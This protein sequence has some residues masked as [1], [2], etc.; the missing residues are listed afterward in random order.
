MPQ[1]Y[2]KRRQ[3]RPN[4]S[5]IFAD[6]PTP[7][8]GHPETNPW[9]L[10]DETVR[11]EDP[12]ST[13][14]LE[15]DLQ[16][17]SIHGERELSLISASATPS[18]IPSPVRRLR[19]KALQD[20]DGNVRRSPR[21]KKK[22]EDDDSSTSPT[23]KAFER[24]ERRDAGPQARTPSREATDSS[25]PSSVQVSEV[26][27]PT[28]P[29]D[30]ALSHSLLLPSCPSILPADVQLHVAPLLN[31]TSTTPTS[32]S[33]WASQLTTHFAITKIAEASYGEVYRL[34]LQ[35]P[36]PDF[37]TAHESVLKLIAL[38]PPTPQLD[39]LT[40][41]Q[42]E[43]VAA[44]SSPEAVASEVR[45]LKHMSPTPGFAQFR[46]L[47][48]ISGAMPAP[49]VIAWRSY[50]KNVKKSEFPDP[51][52]KQ[53]YA[54]DQ[55]W[56]VVE[57]QDAGDDLEDKSVPSIFVVWDIFWAVA[58]ALAKGEV[59]S[60]FEHRDLHTGNVCVRWPD[61]FHKGTLQAGWRDKKLGLTGVDVTLIDYTLSRAQV[62]SDGAQDDLAYLDLEK[63][64]D[65]FEGDGDKDYQYDIYRYMRSAVLYGDA[66]ADI[67]PPSLSTVPRSR[68]G[69]QKDPWRAHN[70]VTN[71]IWLHF[72]LYKLTE[73][74]EEWP[75]S[76]PAKKRKAMPKEEYTAALDLEGKV[77]ELWAL[78]DLEAMKERWVDEGV[79]S[80]AG[81]VGWAVEE[82]WLG[83]DD[84]LG[85]GGNEEEVGEFAQT[86]EGLEQ[87]M[88]RLDIGKGSDGACHEA[89]KARRGRPRKAR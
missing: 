75:S 11:V 24:T 68:R 7:E 37:N 47:R 80:A 1:V 29:L 34:S 2:G 27:T 73:Q 64:L 60:G 15:T 77:H 6:T 83:A 53:A 32:F 4:F 74:L 22:Y 50:D 55:L 46:D 57:M 52:R 67:E 66:V 14:A 88:A 62:S 38:K 21:I 26:L 87:E 86:E 48:I 9:P 3:N 28:L 76:L 20:S 39:K 13:C 17:L 16:N 40:C 45:L 36:H 8:K 85:C 70:P 44:M 30:E 59:A 33:N 42:R 58:C 35:E 5:H 71:L 69:K 19:R 89:T 31:L 56:A 10:P 18:D 78:L 25:A 54:E 65:V 23:R 43:R 12:I 72:I 61:V 79:G 51:G 41:R 49:F 84:V 63:D 81:L 82:G